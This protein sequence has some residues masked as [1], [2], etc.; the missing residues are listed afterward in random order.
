MRNGWEDEVDGRGV[1][2]VSIKWWLMGCCVWLCRQEERSGEIGVEWEDDRRRPRGPSG[3]G[4]RRRR[5][6][7]PRAAGEGT[8]WALAVGLQSLASDAGAGCSGLI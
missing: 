5:C 1:S 7:T 6:R 4:R 8:S 3:R 2:L